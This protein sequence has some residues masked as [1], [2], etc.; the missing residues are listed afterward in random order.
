MGYINKNPELEI[1]EEQSHFYLSEV[2]SYEHLTEQNEPKSALELE[3][4][5]KARHESIDDQPIS[6]KHSVSSG[7]SLDQDNKVWQN[8]EKYKLHENVYIIWALQ[9]YHKLQSNIFWYEL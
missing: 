5:A 3:K 6:I 4:H 1:P 2:P 8:I 9:H 7:T